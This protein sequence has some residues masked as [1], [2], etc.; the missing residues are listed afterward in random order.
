MENIKI[1]LIKEGLE[2]AGETVGG[3]FSS[4]YCNL[5]SVESEN[6]SWK[7]EVAHSFYENGEE[8]IVAKNVFPE[9]LNIIRNRLR[10]VV[11]KCELPQFSQSRYVT[12]RMAFL[13]KEGTSEWANLKNVSIGELSELVGG[14]ALKYFKKLGATTLDYKIDIFK[15]KGTSANQLVMIYTNDNILVP[16]HA[17][18]ATRVFPIKIS[19]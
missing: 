9:R 4:G 16:I 12:L 2:M 18:V 17:Y 7:I 19:V 13:K 3:N 8:E 14:N 10:M 6:S 5:Y 1:N 15:Q 11:N